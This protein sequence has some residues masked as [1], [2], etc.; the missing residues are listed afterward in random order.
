M[1]IFR[2]NAVRGASALALV[3]LVAGVP[4]ARASDERVPDGTWVV[5]QATL[6]G[7]YRGDSKVLNSTWTFRGDALVVQQAGGG[8]Q[9]WALTFDPAAEPAA[10]RATPLDAPDE[11]PVWMILSRRPDELRLAF[12]DGL[13]RRPE[14]FGPRRKLVVLTLVPAPAA[15]PVAD[16]CAILRAAGADRLLGGPTRLQQEP[17]RASRPGVSCALERDD[18]SGTVSLTLVAPPAGTAYVHA[19]RRETE[20]GRRL[21][22]EDEPALGL[23]AFSGARGWTVITVALKQGTAMLLRF[24]APTVARAELRRFSERVRDRL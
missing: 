19:A 21:Q 10:F 7:E 15:A 8:R 4:P 2:A 24:E 11:R 16:P 12:Y 18:G 3:G 20:A 6:N 5:A 1:S 17:P 22:V 14:D 13:D 9:R 23:G